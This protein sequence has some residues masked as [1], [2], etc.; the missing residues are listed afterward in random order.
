MKTEVVK[1]YQWGFILSEQEVRRIAQTCNDHI[2]KNVADPRV[3]IGAALRDGSLI[4]SDNVDDILSLE[5]AGSKR[6][7]R[8]VLTYDDGKEIN[9]WS[10]DLIF[11]D[12][13]VSA[14]SWNSIITQVTGESRDWAFLAAADLE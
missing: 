11:Q 1:H 14:R 2:L 12:A 10:I 8:L 3:I 6:I 4:E 5:N 13:K 7:T 9:D